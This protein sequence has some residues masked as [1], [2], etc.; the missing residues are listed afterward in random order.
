MARP[1]SR[2]ISENSGRE[3]EAGP[4][5]DFCNLHGFVPPAS[6]FRET[7]KLQSAMLRSVTLRLNEGHQVIATP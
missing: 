7:L 2:Q 6:V 3:N 5:D 1:E 4:G